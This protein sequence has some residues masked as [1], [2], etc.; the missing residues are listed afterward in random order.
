MQVRAYNLTIAAGWTS[1]GTLPDG[2]RPDSDTTLLFAGS[3]DSYG[4][5]HMSIAVNATSGAVS[6]GCST[7]HSA[8][9]FSIMFFTA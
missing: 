3:C 1:V 9:S 2:Y 8:A 5:V 4:T 6:T 7:S